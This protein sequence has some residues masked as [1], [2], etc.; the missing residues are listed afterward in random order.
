MATIPTYKSNDCIAVYSLRQ[1]LCEI[2]SGLDVQQQTKCCDIMV[3]SLTT[4][5]ET[6]KDPPYCWSPEKLNENE[7]E[8]KKIKKRGQ[9]ECEGLLLF[10]AVW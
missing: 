3:M 4:N 7:N 8:K 5:I 10:T 9:L 6:S 2:G 1:T